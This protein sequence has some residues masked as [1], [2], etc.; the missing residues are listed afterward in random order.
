MK[1]IIFL[2]IFVVLFS[3]CSSEKEQVY[4]QLEL[5]Y[6]IYDGDKNA[7]DIS[8][9][10]TPTKIDCRY[11]SKGC[12]AFYRGLVKGYEVHFVEFETSAIAK[13]EATK[14]KTLYTRNWMIDYIQNEKILFNFFKNYLKAKKP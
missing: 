1:K 11:Y 14:K 7:T 6:M 13:K 5:M 9:E 3:R 4:S 8:L 12:R 2:L 10:E